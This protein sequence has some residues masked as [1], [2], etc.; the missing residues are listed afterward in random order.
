MS[1]GNRRS[2]VA[3]STGVKQL[4][5]QTDCK[6]AS[7]LVL[8]DSE[9]SSISIVHAIRSLRNRAWYT[10]LFWIP[11]ECNMVA[12]ALSKIITL[13]PYLL[14]LHDSAFTIIQSLLKRDTHGPPYRRYVLP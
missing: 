10:D 2:K 7:S 8:S 1:L 4:H 5:V 13:E 3:W 14:L 9:S 12:A 11:R 6:Q